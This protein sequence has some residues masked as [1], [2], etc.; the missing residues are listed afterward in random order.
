MEKISLKHIQKLGQLAKM[1]DASE[2]AAL[3]VDRRPESAQDLITYWLMHKTTFQYKNL[4]DG[5]T[6]LINKLKDFESG[7]IDSYI[8]EANKYDYT[9]DPYE[10]LMFEF[11]SG[12]IYDLPERIEQYR[13]LLN[14]S[15]S[16]G[17]I[18]NGIE[19]AFTKAFPGLTPYVLAKDQDGND[20]AIPKDMAPKSVQDRIEVNKDLANIETEHCLDSYNEWRKNMVEMIKRKAD[21]KEMLDTI[22]L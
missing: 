8:D 9:F 4:R 12:S 18:A 2:S 15:R 1:T 16:A 10:C 6:V 17:Q 5:L 14:F 11:D 7:N 3:N 21:F 19:S 22:V 20:I 13:E